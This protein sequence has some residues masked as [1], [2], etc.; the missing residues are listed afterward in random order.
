MASLRNLILL[1]HLLNLHLPSG[2]IHPYQLDK[3]ISNFKDVCATFSF[4]FYFEK[5]FLLANSEDL[6]Q[7]PCSENAA[8]D[9]GLHCLPRS[10]K[11]G[12]Q[13]NMG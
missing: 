4:L 9:L 10:Q 11:M 2:P 7:M 6:D 3:S 5:I 8:S 12:R 1:P 13:A